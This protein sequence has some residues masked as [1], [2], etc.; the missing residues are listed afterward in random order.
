MCALTVD[1]ERSGKRWQNKIGMVSVNCAIIT[2][3]KQTHLTVSVYTIQKK[4]IKYLRWKNV[5]K[6][7]GDTMRIREIKEEEEKII[8]LDRACIYMISDGH[9]PATIQNPAHTMA[10]SDGYVGKSLNV[11][12]T[13]GF[14]ARFKVTEEREMTHGEEQAILCM[15]KYCEG[16]LFVSYCNKELRMEKCK[17]IME[18]KQVIE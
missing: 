18:G 13:M 2:E 4:I 3:Q 9:A 5:Q 16:C 10:Q 12:T 17:E 14:T 15:K 11:N 6:G 1:I 7:N 8:S